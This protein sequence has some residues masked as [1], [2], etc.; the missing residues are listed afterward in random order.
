MPRFRS[1]SLFLNDIATMTVDSSALEKRLG[2]WG[3]RVME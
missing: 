3:D 2:N 1:A